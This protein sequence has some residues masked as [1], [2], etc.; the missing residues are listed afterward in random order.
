MRGVFKSVLQKIEKLTNGMKA[1]G[2][3]KKTHVL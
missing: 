1:H 3:K 2:N